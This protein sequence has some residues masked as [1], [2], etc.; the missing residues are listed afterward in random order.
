MHMV[1]GSV[2]PKLTADLYFQKKIWHLRLTNLT[3]P[4]LLKEREKKLQ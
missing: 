3:G 4:H 1:L 2:G